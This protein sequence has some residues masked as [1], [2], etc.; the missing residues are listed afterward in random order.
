MYGDDFDHNEVELLELSPELL[1]LLESGEG[2]LC[3]K[4]GPDDEA[5]LCTRDKTFLVKR[6][7]TSNTLLLM[8]PPGGL[9]L[10]IAGGDGDS[11]DADAELDDAVVN[12][13]IGQQQHQQQLGQLQ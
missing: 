2:Q 7:E 12:G 9:D 6:V 4:G 11:A 5:V 13:E 3:F 10:R 1:A 8:Q